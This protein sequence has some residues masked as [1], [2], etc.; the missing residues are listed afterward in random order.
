MHT[1][2]EISFCSLEEYELYLPDRVHEEDIAAGGLYTVMFKLVEPAYEMG[3]AR[4]PTQVLDVAKDA[5]VGLVRVQHNLLTSR[6]EHM[7]DGDFD[8]F[9]VDGFWQDIFEHIYMAEDSQIQEGYLRSFEVD[10]DNSLKDLFASVPE[11]ELA[12][13]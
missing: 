8:C 6:L 7:E 10:I 12:A 13:A 11:R 5:E 4:Y 9:F 3:A 2:E 1:P